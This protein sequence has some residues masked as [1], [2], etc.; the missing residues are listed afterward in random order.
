MEGRSAAHQLLEQAHMKTHTHARA[1]HAEKKTK[2]QG[3]FWETTAGAAVG[4]E[5]AVV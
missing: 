5:A 3:W 1:L 2:C 4:M